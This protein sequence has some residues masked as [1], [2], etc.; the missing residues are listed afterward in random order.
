MNGLPRALLADLR[1][2]CCGSGFEIV[3]ECTGSDDRLS[4]GVLACDCYEYPVVEGIAVLRQMSPVSSISNGAVDLLRRGDTNGALQWLLACGS[5]PGVQAPSAPRAGRLDSIPILG[6]ALRRLSGRRTVAPAVDLTKIEH[7]ET[8][9]RASR[10]RGYADYLYQRFANPSLLGAI[11]PL[12]VLGQACGLCPRKRLLDVLCGT[13]HSSSTVCALCP[14]L[15]V[16]MADFD[17]VNLYLARRFLAPELTALCVDAEL[18]LPL[19][20][21]SV[22]AVFC[23]DGLHY[24]RS[25]GAFLNEVD[26]IVEPDGHWVFAHMHNRSHANVNAGAPLDAKGYRRHF[27]FGEMRMLPE[28]QVIEQFRAD[29]SLDLTD[30]VPDHVVE[31]SHALTLVGSRGDGLWR[32]HAGLD[33]ML[34]ARPDRLSLNPLY[35][36]ESRNGELLANAVWPSESLKRECTQTEALFSDG[37][38]IPAH[39]L[40]AAPSTQGGTSE[41]KD[42][43]GL[44]RSF[45]LVSLPECYSKVRSRLSL[46]L[47]KIHVAFCSLELSPCWVESCSI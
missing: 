12:L 30:Q 27:S 24:V 47:V 31:E 43:L 29:G 28:H 22:D 45:L 9:L 2:P 40:D 4:D 7:F 33:E 34:L 38:R 21:D 8:A 39:V 1:C 17:Y 37:V 46:E 19:A 18:P 6:S 23:M 20:D 25:K 42:V 10:P 3:A 11:P 15:D 32:R 36:L 14:G 41:S 26:R 16:I 35:R 5:A 13:G 44:I